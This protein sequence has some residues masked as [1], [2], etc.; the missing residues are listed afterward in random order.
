MMTEC[1]DAEGR[2]TVVLLDEVTGVWL[3]VVVPRKKP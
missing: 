1:R 2:R 3:S